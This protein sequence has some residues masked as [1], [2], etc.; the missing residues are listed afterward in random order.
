M[1]FEWPNDEDAFDYGLND[2]QSRTATYPE[3]D[4]ANVPS[5]KDIS[6]AVVIGDITYCG[7]GVQYYGNRML[8][9]QVQPTGGQK[10]GYW[11][12]NYPNIIPSQSY[13]SFKINRPGNV[14]FFQL[15]ASVDGNV[16]RVPTYY[17]AV[18]AKIDGQTVAKVV[19]EYTPTTEELLVSPN[20]FPGGYAS[21]EYKKYYVTLSVSKDDLEGIEEAATVYI[22]HKNPTKNTL[23][24]WY[25]PLTW[26]VDLTG[27]AAPQRLGKI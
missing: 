19:D 2:L 16:P 23:N 13:Q 11:D 25:A 3:E 7:P 9:G 15:V 17:L 12:E 24:V 1:V 26:T 10:G 8:I 20:N 27:A 22:Y 21:A 5:K 18:V 4:T 6:N 14:S